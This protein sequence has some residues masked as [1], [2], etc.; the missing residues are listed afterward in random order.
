MSRNSTSIA[1]NKIQSSK[2]H[3]SFSFYQKAYNP[4][5]EAN[6]KMLMKPENGFNLKNINSYINNKL[7][8]EELIKQKKENG[9]TLNS[10]EQLILENYLK[11]KAEA[12]RNDF[13]LI[14][15]QKFSAIP[16]TKE[17]RLKLLLDILV[18]KIQKYEQLH[19]KQT[20]Q[21][22]EMIHIANIYLR[23]I[24]DDFN[25]VINN[26][27]E[28]KEEYN[29]YLLKMNDIVKKLNLIELQFTRF[30]SQ[31][32]PLNYNGFKKFDQ[33]QIDVINNIDTN[34]STVINAP[35]SAGKSVLSA[36]TTT[37]GRVLFVVP[38]DALAWQMSAYIGC[39][40]GINVPILTATYQTNPN[41]DEMI[42]SLNRSEAIVGTPEQL[43]DYFPFIHNKFSWIVFDEIHMIGKAEGSAMEYI[44]KI[45][46]EIPIL[47]LSATIGNT[48]EL[49]LW[50]NNLYPKKKINKVICDKR[51]FNLQRFYYDDNNNSLIS[52][53]PLALVE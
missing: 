39:I 44:A 35:T 25:A 31:M 3:W 38:T 53:N 18:S 1:N 28:L 51:F 17:G 13:K 45:F 4:D 29:V 46:P 24:E 6:I 26:Y 42:D 21:T 20:S 11:K 15:I 47:A 32:P 16:Q 27:P 2:G 49:V 33:W 30:H 14:E 43:V 10:A 41:R 9:K 22:E 37:K 34:I 5:Q 8:K 19:T 23:L 50:F 40:L 48:D 52:L 12:I 7:S 36:Y